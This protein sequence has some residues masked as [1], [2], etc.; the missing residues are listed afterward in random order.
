MNMGPSMRGSKIDDWTGGFGFIG[1]GSYDRVCHVSW[2]FE[3]IYLWWHFWRFQWWRLDSV[4]DGGGLGLGWV[5]SP[6]RNCHRSFSPM[7]VRDVVL[8]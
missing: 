3:D 5:A 2:K 6:M 1:G 7:R 4:R 8:P